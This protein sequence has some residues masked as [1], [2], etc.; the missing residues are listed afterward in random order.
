MDTISRKWAC[1]AFLWYNNNYTS[2]F[3]K[4]LNFDIYY[5][6]LK[7]IFNELKKNSLYLQNI[8]YFKYCC[9]F[10]YIYPFLTFLEV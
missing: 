10:E 1:V 8:G 7:Y 4:I 2:V 5:I 9:L 3:L 6:N